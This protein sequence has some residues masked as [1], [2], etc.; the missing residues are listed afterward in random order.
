LNKQRNRAPFDIISNVVFVIVIVLYHYCVAFYLVF[1][2]LRSDV[3][4][5]KKH[6]IFI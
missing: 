1:V 4:E 2:Q 3:V 6:L 5:L